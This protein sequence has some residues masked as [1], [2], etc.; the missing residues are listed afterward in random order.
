MEST[1]ASAATTTSNL[2]T[3]WAVLGGVAI[4]ALGAWLWTRRSA[5]PV[6]AARLLRDAAPE[7]SIQPVRKVPFQNV[8]RLPGRLD[9]ASDAASALAAPIDSAPAVPPATA[10]DVQAKNVTIRSLREVQGTPKP[11]DKSAEAK[12]KNKPNFNSRGPAANSPETWS[13]VPHRPA[14]MNPTTPPVLPADEN[15]PLERGQN[16]KLDAPTLTPP[17][18]QKLIDSSPYADVNFALLPEPPSEE[19]PIVQVGR[20]GWSVPPTKPYSHEEASNK[21]PE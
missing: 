15:Q 19:K 10:G 4:G 13:Q 12:R 14:A 8:W 17:A 7:S 6:E 5:R 3:I 9:A 16:I 11:A 2:T 1:A 20:E 21:T 18:I